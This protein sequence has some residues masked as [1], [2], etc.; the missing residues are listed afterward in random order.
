MYTPVKVVYAKK[1]T[2]IRNNIAP[3]MDKTLE[4]FQQLKV[5]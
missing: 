3:G 5:N 4:W 1:I 2:K